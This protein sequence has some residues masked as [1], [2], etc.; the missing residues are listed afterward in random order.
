MSRVESS[1]HERGLT[2]RRRF[3]PAPEA[4]DDP[5]FDGATHYNNVR[6][7]DP[8]PTVDSGTQFPYGLDGIGGYGSDL[9]LS[10]AANES[11]YDR[12]Q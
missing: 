12:G 9:G 1:V 3:E 11:V 6:L 4:N 10:A 5:L 8:A 7:F 2:I